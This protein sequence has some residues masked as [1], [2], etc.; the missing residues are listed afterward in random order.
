MVIFHSYVSLPEGSQYSSHDV[1]W[2]QQ[3]KS[4]AQVAACGECYEHPPC[5]FSWRLWRAR[6]SPWTLGVGGTSEGVWL[7]DMHKTHT[8]THT[9]IYI[10]EFACIFIIIIVIVI[11]I[12]TIIIITII[13]ISISISII[14]IIV[15]IYMICINTYV[16]YIHA[17]KIREPMFCSEHFI[18][19]GLG[20]SRYSRSRLDQ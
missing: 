2:L 11:I 17:W 3:E 14:S 10:C 5:R 8:D 18:A 20:P 13:S 4:L 6:P 9:Y 16:L 19:P 15:Y 12:S 7:G 1:K